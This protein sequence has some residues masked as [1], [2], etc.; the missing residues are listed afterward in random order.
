M[1]YM[2]L[3]KS[4]FEFKEMSFLSQ[5]INNDWVKNSILAAW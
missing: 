1:I 4:E 3:L 2:F 5:D